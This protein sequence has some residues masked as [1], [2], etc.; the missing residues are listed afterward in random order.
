MQD[1]D[2]KTD[3]DENDSDLTTTSELL[4]LQK[5]A[6]IAEEDQCPEISNEQVS[7]DVKDGIIMN[8]PNPEYEH[9]TNNNDCTFYKQS[10]TKQA[11]AGVF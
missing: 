1:I 8:L 4:Q 11:L 7:N 9:E 10:L 5:S 2:V 3:Q 6:N